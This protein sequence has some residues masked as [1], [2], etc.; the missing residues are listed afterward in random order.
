MKARG[1]ASIQPQP[2]ASMV[3]IRIVEVPYQWKGLAP[4][5]EIGSETNDSFIKLEH[6]P[7]GTKYSVKVTPTVH[8][9]E[10]VSRSRAKAK[11][12]FIKVLHGDV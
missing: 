3:D 9:R 4:D 8:D 7:S 10:M 12:A 11:L 6:V 5:R 1:D 2:D